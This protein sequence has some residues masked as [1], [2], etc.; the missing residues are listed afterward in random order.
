MEIV[1]L[2]PFAEHVMPS[3][4][5]DDHDLT[6]L[7]VMAS[8]DLPQPHRGT[9][10]CRADEQPPPPISDAYHGDPSS[11][12]LRVEGQSTAARPG[13]D[14]YVRGHAW[15]PNGRPTQ[16]A[17]LHVRVGPCRHSALVVGERVWVRSFATLT[18]TRPAPFEHMPIVWERSFGGSPVGVRGR[19]AQ[20]SARNPVGR[21]LH[22]D[23]AAADGQPLPNFEDLSQPIAS[24]GDLPDPVGFGPIARHWQPRLSFAGTYDQAWVET[25]APLWP[26]DMD[27]RLFFAAAPG[28][29]A[30]P[31]LR[32]GEP[33]QLL[34]LHPDGPIGFELPSLALTAR[35]EFRR[36]VVE[37]S[38][39][40]DAVDIDV[41]RMRLALIWR[42]AVPEDMLEIQSLLVRELA[43]WE[44]T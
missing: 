16:Q 28:L 39:V 9:S 24:F 1:N 33:V 18:A 21:G 32:G 40:L 11:S 26:E 23:Q 44:R 10:L 36:R 5:R 34:G 41:D 4:S 27:E 3:M 15:G 19:Q 2:T 42:T 20:I 12:S 43:A 6:L 17:E 7:V 8:F 31:H 25:R 29:R 37:Q 38:L 22:T 14:I 30:Q 13:T 35:F